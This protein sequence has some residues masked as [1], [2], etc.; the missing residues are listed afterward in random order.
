MK[1]NNEKTTVT[2][3]ISTDLKIK[4]EAE[5]ERRGDDMSKIMDLII[6]SYLFRI[7]MIRLDMGTL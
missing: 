2:V 5:C 7:T 6:S 4:L 3:N 1:K